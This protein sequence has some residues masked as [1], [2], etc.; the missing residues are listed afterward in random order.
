MKNKTQWRHYLVIFLPAFM[1][2]AS[3]TYKERVLPINLPLN[4]ENRVTINGLHIS[5]ISF[6]NKESAKKAFGFDVRKAGLLPV[7]I[8]FQN[9]GEETVTIIPEQTFLIDTKNRAWPINS[10]ERTYKRVEDYYRVNETIAGAGEPALLLGAAGAVVGLAIGIV[11]GEDLGESAGKGAAIGGAAGAIMGG[12]DSYQNAK[13]KINDDLY[14]KSLENKE[15]LPTQIAYGA[16]FFPGFPDEAH[17]ASH[18]KITLSFG[19]KTQAATI[20]LLSYLE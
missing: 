3:C 20:D 18:L 7:Q 8:A 9:E 4:A 16:L 5:A 11:T 6:E 2:F 1:L 14:E 10:L 17:G 15:I 19:E 13:R 12:T